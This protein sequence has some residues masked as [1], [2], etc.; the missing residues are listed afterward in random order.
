MLQAITGIP[1]FYR[2]FGYEMAL[3]L[4]AGRH[5]HKS[6]VPKLA[7]GAEELYRLRPAA[8]ADLPFMAR[9]YAQAR[10]RSLVSS[11]LSPRLWRYYLNGRTAGEQ[12]RIIE[13]PQGARVGLLAHSDAFPWG[14][15]LGTVLYE[16]TPGTS[17]LA[18][19]PSV[20]RYL[21]ATGAEY[22]AVEKKEFEWIGF[23][24]GTQHPAY[25]AM[26]DFLQP[27]GDPYAFYVRVPDLPGFLR[28]IAPA[29][30]A[31]LANSIAP[32]WTGELKLSF[33]RDGL[34]LA[35]EQGK[36]K[37]SEPWTPTRE[38]ESACFRG[39]TFL[40]LLFGLH[41]MEDLRRINP[42]CYAC[43][44][45]ARVL[46]RILFPKQPSSVWAVA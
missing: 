15:T 14:T 44:N 1:N 12:F 37:T 26:P 32:G 39:G 31:R 6:G 28:L 4:D 18:V 35:F 27:G 34:R 25:E 24:L 30:E 7:T 41:T 20:L 10:T 5:G 11:V 29:L 43:N 38:G 36:L 23:Q 16:L 8:E 40:H 17:W 42:E 46:L 3:E 22:A 9:T 33:F 13:T 21:A 45:D 2:Q 19:T